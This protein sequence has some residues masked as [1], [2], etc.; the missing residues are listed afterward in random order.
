M[1]VIDCRYV[2]MVGRQKELHKES[3]ISVDWN[4]PVMIFD[5][6][7]PATFWITVTED[8]Y[9]QLFFV[10]WIGELMKVLRLVAN[11]IAELVLVEE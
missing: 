8:Y 11:N 3:F 1:N 6:N 10:M 5:I 9:S 4:H 7:V 2:E